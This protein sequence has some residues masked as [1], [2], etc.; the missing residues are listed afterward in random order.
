MST[1][2]EHYREAENLITPR[3]VTA[4]RM[5]APSLETIL[6][7]QV[8]ATLALVAATAD[9]SGALHGA[10]PGE[11]QPYESLWTDAMEDAWLTTETFE[12]GFRAMLG[13]ME[14]EGRRLLAAELVR[15]A[16]EAEGQS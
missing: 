10:T 1:G 12:G 16:D 4:G 15:S 3:R 11:I 7:A 6:Q 8:H 14:P 5:A 9:P 2:L 13:A